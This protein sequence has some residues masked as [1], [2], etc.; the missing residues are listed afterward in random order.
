[1]AAT[2]PVIHRA[3]DRETLAPLIELC[4]AGRLF[5]VQAWIAAG[6]PVNLPPPPA[7]GRRPKSPLEVAI[8]RGFHSLV[9][10]LLEAGAV[11]EPEGYKAPM[12]QA[13][14]ARRF[15]IVQLLV[16]HG[17][18]P[19][20]INMSEVFET[21]DRETMEY[22]IERGADLKTGHPFAWAFYERIR[23]ALG[24]YKRCRE[25]M[26]ELQ[27]QVDIALRHHCKEGNLK[28]VSL[29]LWAGADPFKPGPDEPGEEPDEDYG[30]LSAIA[31]AALRDHYEVL[32]LKPIRTK[33]PGPDPV[34]LM[35]NLTSGRGL[36]ILKRLLEKGLDPN[37]QENG[38]CSA[39][40]SCLERMSW[41][42]LSRSYTWEYLTRRDRDDRSLDSD[43]AR[44]QLKAIH[45]LAKH[46]AKWKPKDKEEIG[47]ARRSLL[48]MTPDY[49]V[50]F[51]WIMAG[52]QACER[53]CVKE[54]LRTPSIRSHTA[55]HRGRLEELMDSW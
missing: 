15:D 37:D 26:P 47:L 31:Y 44:D 21:W 17:F 46:G 38:G 4:K 19:K 14:R 41:P 9:Q 53:E 10:V 51:V 36:E 2:A 52:Y 11:Q 50:E 20:T 18:D 16:E 25:R 13:L 39:I 22:F 3:A 54:L 34:G 23:T 7:K 27:E 12:Y 55:A 29:M 40:R 32:E 1:M 33:L 30:G 24:V 48:K 6:K 5:D 8:D 35:S 45:L 43:E 42:I 28:W 49:A